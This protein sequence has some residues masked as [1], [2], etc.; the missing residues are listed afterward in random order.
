MAN[1][2]FH[3]RSAAHNNRG[4]TLIELLVVISIIA[5]LIGILLPALA[6][7]RVASRNTQD[8]ANMRSI[9]QALEIYLNTFNGDYFPIHLPEGSTDPE[10]DHAEWHELMFSIV[11]EMDN[12]VMRSPIDPL[13]NFQI[14]HEGD[15]E[16][17]ISYSINGY[18]EV[19][20]ANRKN[21]FQPSEIVFLGHRGDEDLD[22]NEI[23]D[24]HDADEIHFAFHP[25]EAGEDWWEHLAT[26]RA[27]GGTNYLFCD[28][29]VTLVTPENLTNEMAEPGD[30][31]HPAEE[32]D[33]GHP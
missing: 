23:T 4:F 7:A 15:L 5:L 24:G 19:I 27:H 14:D 21:M 10:P 1:A 11:P 12:S 28:G 17:I 6:S 20:N 31:F 22:G 9:G 26:E 16:P 18:F 32:H 8:K 33:H 2:P 13:E 29:H 3:Y 25:W 30:R